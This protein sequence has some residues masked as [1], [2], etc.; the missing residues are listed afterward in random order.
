MTS[1]ENLL[2]ATEQF[3]STHANDLQ[4]VHG[5]GLDLSISGQPQYD[6]YNLMLPGVY[7][8]DVL[9]SA[10]TLFYA[11]MDKRQSADIYYSYSMDGKGRVMCT[12]AGGAEQR[13]NR[14]DTDVAFWSQVLLAS[15]MN[16]ELALLVHIRRCGGAVL[17]EGEGTVTKWISKGTESENMIARASSMREAIWKA[18]SRRG[19]INLGYAYISDDDR[20]VSVQWK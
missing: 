15:P 18:T 14:F 6:Y 17:Q 5:P 19:S 12:S 16:P 2:L 7:D 11:C 10:Y 8:I 20:F 9:L 4:Y 13:K 3:R 1:T